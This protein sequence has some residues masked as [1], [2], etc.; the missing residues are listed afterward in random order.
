ME[1][2]GSAGLG[3]IDGV[4]NQFVDNPLPSTPIDKMPGISAIMYSPNGRSALNQFYDLK[5][6]SDRVTNSLGKYKGERL[7][8]YLN[9]N[10][11]LIGARDTIN[12]LNDAI[13]ELRAERT[14]VIDN[15]NF[16]AKVKATKLRGIEKRMNKI[17]KPVSSIRLQA[18]LPLFSTQ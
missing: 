14:E 18:D 9:D 3:I 11:K 10:A 1:L 2:L 5:D 13:K 15:K 6:L 4:I 17:L 7:T 16:S 12:A 8:K